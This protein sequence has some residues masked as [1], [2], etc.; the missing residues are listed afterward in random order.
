MKDKI[1]DDTSHT[2]SFSENKQESEEKE[3][4]KLLD[5]VA[6]TEDIPEHNLKREEVGTVVEILSG[7][8]AFEVEFSDD[9]GQMYKCSSFLESQLEVLHSETLEANLKMTNQE[10]HTQNDILK[11]MKK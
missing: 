8:E 9:N 11:N 4:I 5:V 6:L 1:S 2:N 10:L 7:G 3:K